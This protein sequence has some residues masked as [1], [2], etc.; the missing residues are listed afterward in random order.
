MSTFLRAVKP[1][2]ACGHDDQ[3]REGGCAIKE[4]K[5]AAP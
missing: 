5:A 3:G 2:R 1:G 4:W